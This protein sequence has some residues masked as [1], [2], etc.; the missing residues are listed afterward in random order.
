MPGPR[1]APTSPHE[2][3]TLLERRQ[4]WYSGSSGGGGSAG[5]D[6][7]QQN[8]ND[9]SIGAGRRAPLLTPH[10][11]ASG[12]AVLAETRLH[13]SL[14]QSLSQQQGSPRIS[15]AGR[16]TDEAASIIPYSNN[17]SLLRVPS[18]PVTHYSGQHVST[19]DM[20]VLS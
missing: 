10:S 18:D 9:G 12:V 5:R 19:G 16:A 17:G 11:P 3:P 8:R 6:Q 14:Q 7:Q 15:A 1:Q 20:R 4:T 2:E 13:R